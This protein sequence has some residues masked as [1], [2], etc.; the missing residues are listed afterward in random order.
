MWTEEKREKEEQ[1][2]KDE[3]GAGEERSWGGSAVICVAQGSC[4][5]APSSLSNSLSR[6]DEPQP[7]NP[8]V[9]LPFFRSA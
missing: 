7:G 5:L 6:L 9:F 8:S 2:A 3:R 4:L 1:K